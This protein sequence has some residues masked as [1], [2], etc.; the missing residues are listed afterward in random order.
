MHGMTGVAVGKGVEIAV[1]CVSL[2]APSTYVGY[3][4]LTDPEVSLGNGRKSEIRSRERMRALALAAAQLHTWIMV[5][6]R[7]PCGI[8]ETV[9]TAG[10]G[11]VYG[12]S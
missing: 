5:L 10:R 9:S 11:M 3:P 12:G 2:F 7:T 4:P 6:T 8:D 1:T